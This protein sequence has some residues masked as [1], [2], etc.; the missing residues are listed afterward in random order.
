[1]NQPIIRQPR[2]CLPGVAIE[3]SA[4]SHRFRSALPHLADDAHSNLHA[5]NMSADA[6]ELIKRE[7][8]TGLGNDFDGAAAVI[9]SDLSSGGTTQKK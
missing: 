5:K 3:P 2:N 4:G 1:M 8:N 6:A 7:P 9:K